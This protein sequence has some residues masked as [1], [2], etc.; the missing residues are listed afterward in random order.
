MQLFMEDADTNLDE[1]LDTISDSDVPMDDE[2]QDNLTG[3]DDDITSYL[4]W[5]SDEPVVAPTEEPKSN[6]ENPSRY[7]YWQS[8]AT[9]LENELKSVQDMMPVIQYLKENPQALQKLATPEPEPMIQE[10]V[11]PQI[12]RPVAPVKPE[13]FNSVDAMNEPES[14]SWKWR[15]ANENYRLDVLDY[16]AKLEEARQEELLAQRERETAITQQQQ[17][18]NDAKAFLKTKHGFTEDKAQDFITK[19]SDPSS[20][21][22]DNLVRLYMA[23]EEANPTRQQAIKQFKQQQVKAK[24][25]LPVGIQGGAGGYEIS[26]QDTFNLGLLNYRKR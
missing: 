10:P 13:G 16:Y 14:E 20:F 17:K 8:Q 2:G 6:K 26:E 9:K 24:A 15:E 19:M 18:I 23:N 4:G 12:T 22:M 21:S 7:E 3:T 1:G 11:K 5:E 25:P